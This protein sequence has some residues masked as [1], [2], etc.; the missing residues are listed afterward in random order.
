MRRSSYAR[1][2]AIETKSDYVNSHG[3]KSKVFFASWI[4]KTAALNNLT[5]FTLIYMKA[6]GHAVSE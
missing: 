6:A 3:I 1:F 5:A 4:R 2:I